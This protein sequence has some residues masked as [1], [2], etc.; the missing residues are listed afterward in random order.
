MPDLDSLRVD[1][2]LMIESTK[3]LGKARIEEMNRRTAE[4]LLRP[5]RTV[6]DRSKMC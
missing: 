6:S 4:K 3:E 1:D 2:H 5:L